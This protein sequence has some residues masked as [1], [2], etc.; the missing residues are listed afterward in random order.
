MHKDFCGPGQIFGEEKPEFH[1][2]GAEGKSF[3][4]T[5]SS[6]GVLCVSAVNTLLQ[7]LVVALPRPVFA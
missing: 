1:R 2:G 7:P 6:L 3:Y 5:P 4:E